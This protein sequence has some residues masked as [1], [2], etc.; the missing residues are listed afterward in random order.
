VIDER[1]E[2]HANPKIFW[3]LAV[4]GWGIIVYGFVGLVANSSRTHPPTWAVWFFGAAI[5]HDLLLAPI[6]L[7]IGS[8][9]AL[10]APG[11]GKAYVQAALIMSGIVVLTSI[12]VLLGFGRNPNDPSTLPNNY[13]T[14]LLAVLAV[15]WTL[16]ALTSLARAES[17]SQNSKDEQP[18][19]VS[20]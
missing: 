3:P 5:V 14:G 17:R 13:I 16:V 2:I 7:L 10:R 18:L 1:P 15:I 6:V 8:Q 20:R 9:I 4:L 11:R 12:P 19:Q